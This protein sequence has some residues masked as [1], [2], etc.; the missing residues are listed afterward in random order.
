VDFTIVNVENAA[1]GRGVTT[2]IAVEV[3]SL[4][5]DCLT[6]GN[7]AFDQR[8]VLDYYAAQPRLLRP[9]NYPPECPGAGVFVGETAAGTPVAVINIMGRVHMAAHLDDPFRA[10]DA[11]VAAVGGRAKAVVV[12]MHAEVTSEKAAMGWHLDGRVS[13]VVGTHTHVTT[14][15]ERVLPGGTAYITDVGMVGTQD[16]VIGGDRESSLR[17]FRTQMPVRIAPAGTEAEVRGV[18]IDVDETSGRAR[19]ITRILVGPEG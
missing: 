7:H 8:D 1:S 14:A 6:N 18:V 4:G 19:S 11:A 16:G 12:D 15:D 13:A 17:R 5:A 9:A 3:L 2:Q 10:A